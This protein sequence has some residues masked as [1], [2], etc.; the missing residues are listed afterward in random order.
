MGNCYGNDQ[1]SHATTA[2]HRDCRSRCGLRSAKCVYPH[3]CRFDG[4]RITD[5]ER[6]RDRPDIVMGHRYILGQ[7]S[8][9]RYADRLFAWTDTFQPTGTKRTLSTSEV[10]FNG[11]PLTDAPWR[12][13]CSRSDNAP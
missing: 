6:L 3:S 8:P 5:G 4:G 10:R 12:H 1:E 13:I 7:P 2:D 11:Y 9:A